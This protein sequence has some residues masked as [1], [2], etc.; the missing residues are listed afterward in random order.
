MTQGYGECCTGQGQSGDYFIDG[1]DTA[2]FNTCVQTPNGSHTA[3]TGN[4]YGLDNMKLTIQNH[5]PRQDDDTHIR[6]AASLVVIFLTDEASQELKNNSACDVGEPPLDPDYSDCMSFPP[7]PAH[8]YDPYYNQA[9]DDQL[10]ADYLPILQQENAQAH[11]ILVPASEPDCSDQGMRGRGYEDLINMVGG[12]VGSICQNDFNAT[13]N[14]IVQDIAG[15]SSAIN[16]QHVPITVSIAV[17]IERKDTTPSTYEPL[18]RSRV[19]GFDY[20]ASSNRIVLVNQPM[21]FPPYDVVV[22]YERWVTNM[23]GPD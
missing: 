7:L 21:D 11:G 22:S 2:T 19:E 8:C 13:M 14:L 1:T 6:P 15:G 16:L 23:V 4:E 20:R 10:I 3:D 17:A 5:L 9:C 18:P 12:Q